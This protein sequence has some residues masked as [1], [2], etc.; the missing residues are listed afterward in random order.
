MTFAKLYVLP[1]G[2]LY[3]RLFLFQG[4]ENQREDTIGN[5]AHNAKIL[6][7]QTSTAAICGPK[8]REE[9]RIIGE[10]RT[11]SREEGYRF[12]ISLIATETLNE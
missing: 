7:E 9:D 12:L 5:A 8:S 2:Y 11:V 3:H 10:R 4:T 6:A 1:D